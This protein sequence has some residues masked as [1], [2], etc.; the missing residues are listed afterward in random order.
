MTSV[1]V[2]MNS[3]NHTG[4]TMTCCRM[5]RSGR[6]AVNNNMQRVIAINSNSRGVSANCTC[7]RQLSYSSSR[8]ASS[9]SSNWRDSFIITREINTVAT[10]Q[11]PIAVACSS[12][13]RLSRTWRPVWSS[14][15]SMRN[16]Y[17]RGGVDKLWPCNKIYKPG[18]RLLA[19]MTGAL[20][21]P[22]RWYLHLRSNYRRLRTACTKKIIPT[23]GWRTLTAVLATS[24]VSDYCPLSRTIPLWRY[25]GISDMC[26]NSHSSCWIYSTS[27]SL[28]RRSCCGGGRILLKGR[29]GLWRSLWLHRRLRIRLRSNGVNKIN[30]IIRH[31]S[32]NHSDITLNNTTPRISLSKHRTTFYH[33]GSKST[34]F[35]K[36]S[37]KT[38]NSS[39]NKYKYF[40]L[41]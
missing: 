25:T 37:S 1:E 3:A 30:S 19:P 32:H 21:L 8:T 11:I 35:T 17:K 40:F 41:L 2:N 29:L 34:Y 20:W 31:S 16:W 7:C 23:V 27:M 12:C 39:L 10:T 18:D 36:L 9:P 15:M 24:I 4:R 22:C 26:M 28:L 33:S 5:S 38:T 13:T 14:I 6:R